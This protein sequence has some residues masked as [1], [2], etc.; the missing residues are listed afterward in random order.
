MKSLLQPSELDRHFRW[1]RGRSL[2]LAK[3]GRIPHV[4]LPPKEEI[5]FDPDAIDNWLVTLA[6]ASMQRQEVANAN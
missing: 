6:T 1:P 3:A 5:R 2:R 4:K